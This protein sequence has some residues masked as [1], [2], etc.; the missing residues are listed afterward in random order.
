MYHKLI[1]PVSCGVLRNNPIIT[2]RDYIK[3]KEFKNED[4]DAISQRSS[5]S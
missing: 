5:D 4:E 1:L 3:G 2:I